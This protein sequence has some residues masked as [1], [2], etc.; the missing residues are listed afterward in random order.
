MPCKGC[1]M[2]CKAIII[3]IDMSCIKRTGG[4]DAEFIS[5][6]WSELSIED[7][8]LIN[9][10]LQKWIDARCA[11]INQYYYKCDCLGLDNKCS[12]H[13]NGKPPVCV[14]F[15]F[16]NRP[17]KEKTLLY[18]E[19]CGYQKDVEEFVKNAKQEELN[20]KL[21]I[22]EPDKERLFNTIRED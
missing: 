13:E 17:I 19:D 4:T 20:R 2:C 6:H 12:V 5:K 14:N 15:P 10:Y 9:P 8:L 3:D 1:G 22:E 7:A 18:T 16:Y 11:G 21:N